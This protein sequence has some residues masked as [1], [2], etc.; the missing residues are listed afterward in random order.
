MIHGRMVVIG[1][2]GAIAKKLPDVVKEGMQNAILWWWKNRLPLHFK[3]GAAERY[4]YAKRTP[5]YEFRKQKRK[6]H[7]QPLVYSGAMRDELLRR[8]DVTGTSRAATGRMNAP[9]HT[10]IITRPTKSAGAAI[11]KVD[12][13]LATTDREERAMALVVDE[14]I[15]RILNDDQTVDVMEF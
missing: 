6:H 5:A 15:D 14:T 3:H 1:G 8:I 11:N 12:E 4:G 2:P 9:R 10:F 7:Q 13:I